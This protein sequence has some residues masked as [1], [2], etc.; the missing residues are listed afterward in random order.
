MTNPNRGRG[1][2]HVNGPVLSTSQPNGTT[3]RPASST[4]DQDSDGP[5]GRGGYRQEYRRPPVAPRGGYMRGREFA[6]RGYRGGFRG[7]GGYS[8]APPV[9]S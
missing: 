9:S 8:A 7:R 5:R 1:G 6:N 4:D 2:A 3:R